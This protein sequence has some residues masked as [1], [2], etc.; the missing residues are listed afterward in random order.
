VGLLVFDVIL[1]GALLRGD[2]L[3]SDLRALWLF[4]LKTIR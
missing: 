1:L 2:R 3:A 4:L